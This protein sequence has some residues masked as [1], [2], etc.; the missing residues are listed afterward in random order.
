MQTVTLGEVQLAREDSGL[1]VAFPFHAGTGTAASSAVYFQLDPGVA[2]G[3]HTDSAEEIVVILEGNAEAIVGDERGLLQAGDAAVVPA[4]VPHDVRN[5]GDVPL[6]VLG[7][8]AGSAV[9]HVFADAP[10]PDAPRVFVTGAPVRIAAQ[11][12]EPVAI[13]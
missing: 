3:T 12:D 9:V 4:S 13:A 8:F 6:R 10:A 2:V 5:V 7:F 1:R 11:L